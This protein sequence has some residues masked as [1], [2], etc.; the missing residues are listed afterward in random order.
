MPCDVHTYMPYDAH[1]Y[2]YAHTCTAHTLSM[3]AHV[4]V[5]GHQCIY[6]VHVHTPY[7]SQREKLHPVTPTQ[8]GELATQSDVWVIHQVTRTTQ[9]RSLTQ[10]K[11]Q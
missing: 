2:S 8:W 10:Q 3:H 9:D 7:L 6:N 11:A 1:T 5:H 4:D